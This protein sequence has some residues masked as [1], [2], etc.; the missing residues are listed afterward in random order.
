MSEKEKYSLLRGLIVASV[1][2]IPLIVTVSQSTFTNPSATLLYIASLL[3]YIGIVLL[4][5]MYILGTKSIIG[6]YFH[7]MAK[8]NQLHSNFGKYG[9][10]LIFAHPIAATLSYGQ[11][12]L[13]YSLVPNISTEFEKHVTYGRLAIFVLLIIWLTSAIMRGKIAFRPWKYI[14][15]LTYL[16]L[17]LA[18]LHIP[19]I[20]ISYR[21]Q[22]GAQFYYLS[23]LGLFGLFSLFRI[24]QLFSLGKAPYIIQS[25]SRA[26][27]D[28]MLLHLTS[29]NNKGISANKGQYLYLQMRLLGEEHPFSILQYDETTGDLTV[30]YKTFGS[31][32]NKLSRLQPG[33]KLYVD[34]PYG[35]F[36]EQIQ[37]SLDK[38]VVFVAGGIGITPFVDHILRSSSD[39]Q[40]LFY[41]NQTKESAVFSAPLKAKLGEHCVSI[42]SAETSAVENANDE[43]GYVSPGLF[44]KY[45]IRPADYTYF[46]CG[47]P[48]MMDITK[49]SL[50]GLGV[51]PQQIYS[52]NFS[53]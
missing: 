51:A 9:L 14:H 52:E 10:L 47:P 30:A 29:T 22:L 5:W 45:L 21:T 41:A 3:G 46:I 7:D 12:L 39:E 20:G 34:G 32:T 42:L 40:W 15:Y 43:R 44:Q 38:P 50:I 4:L 27:R 13:L 23:V 1:V 2:P 17:P 19:D 35:T 24:R 36:T 11:N 48:R 37:T 28:V 33:T 6:L 25:H 31:F 8:I 18:L 16:A 53:F 26:S 49:E